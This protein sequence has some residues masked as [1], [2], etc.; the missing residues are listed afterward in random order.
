[1]QSRRSGLG[2]SRILHATG[3]PNAVRLAVSA[4]HCLGIVPN[5]SLGAI[6]RAKS[7]KSLQRDAGGTKPSSR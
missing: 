6:P 4:I 3:E 2:S 7:T 1:M 5:S